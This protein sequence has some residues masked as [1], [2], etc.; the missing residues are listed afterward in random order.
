MKRRLLRSLILIVIATIVA[1][2]FVSLVSPQAY[3][4]AGFRKWKRDFA[5]Y[6]QRKGIRKSTFNKAFRG[7]DKPDPEVLELARYQPEF[8]QKL[9]MYFDSR[10]NETSVERGQQEKKK[11]ARWLNLIERQYGV[12]P[13]IILAIWSME[14]T[15]GEAMKRPRSLR[16]IVRSLSTLAYADRRRRKF[17]RSQLISALKI[18]QSG[19]IGVD[20]LRGSWAGAMGHTQFIPSSYLAFGQDI[21]KDG[22][23]D[24]WNSI[25]DAMATAANLLKR[26]GWRPGRTWGYEVRVPKS[27]RSQAGKTRN[28]NSWAKLGI[29]RVAGRKFPPS[30]DR[31]VL[32]FPAG[33]SGPA[34]LMLRNFFVL[35]RYNNSNKYA[36]AVG[37][38]AD[39]IGGA[40]ELIHAIP[41]PYPKLPLAQR[42]ELQRLLR[43]MGLYD[44]DIDGNIGSG[45]RAAIRRAQIQMGLNPTGFESPGF[46]ARLRKRS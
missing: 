5:A 8:R 40:G 1:P 19:Q 42:K 26:N 39:Q 11:W 36:L 32:M 13:N 18:L 45:T 2:L 21:D 25:P 14:S 46:L 37:H 15:Y 35:K 17:A 38:L 12:S 29:K 10:V 31:A 20:Q 34:F 33:K 23:K 7:I 27:V 28:L 16:S 6:S 9:W 41:R 30:N 4:D 22:K 43:A 3:A 44:K 24:I